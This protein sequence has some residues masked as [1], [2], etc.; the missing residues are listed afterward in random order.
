MTPI[1]LFSLPRS[2]ST[3][4]QR[5]LASPHAVTTTSEPWLLLP[6]L[7]STRQRGVYAEYAHRVASQAVNDFIEELPEKKDT[8]FGRLRE[9]VMK[10]YCDAS[11]DDQSFFLDKTPRYHLIVD[12]IIELFP[13]AKFIFLWRNPLAVIASM[14]GTW[15]R[16]KWNIPSYRIDLFNGVSRLCSAQSKYAERI[17]VV[18]YEDLVTN[19]ADAVQAIFSYIGIEYSEEHLHAFSSIKLKGT[20]GDPTGV[21]AYKSISEQPLNKWR[22]QLGNPLRRAWCR[23]YIRW[24]GAERLALM[25]YEEEEML[26]QL[27][28]ITLSGRHLLSDL[29][30]LARGYFEVWSEPHILREKLHYPF[31]PCNI[32][33]HK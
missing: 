3:L 13:D 15:G 4:L 11:R 14:V 17:H 2:G 20:M 26:A 1:F 29:A 12:E 22:E 9:Y 27:K 33:M 10:L 32:H 18:H 23:R 16:D 8:Y 21:K 6:L 24:I 31:D 28:G 30:G 7:Y 5:V 25:G 19:S